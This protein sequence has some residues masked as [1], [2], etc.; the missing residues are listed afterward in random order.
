M[1]E[2]TKDVEMNWAWYRLN[3]WFDDETEHVLAIADYAVMKV[4]NDTREQYGG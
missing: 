2:L 1:K 4:C 3:G